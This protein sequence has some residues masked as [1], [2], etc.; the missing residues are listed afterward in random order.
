MLT[1]NPTLPFV[2]QRG[3]P[4]ATN[5]PLKQL[6]PFCHP[7]RS[8]GIC[9]FL[10]Q[11]PIPTGNPT[12][13][14]SSSN[15]SPPETTL[16]FVIPSEAEGSAV[17]FP[18][19]QFLLET[20]PHPCPPAT[21]LPLKQPSP[22]SSRAKP[23]DLQFPFPATNSYWKPHPTLVIPTGAKRSGGTC[24]SPTPIKFST[25]KQRR[26]KGTTYEE[27]QSPDSSGA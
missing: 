21:N 9:S 1:G 27:A 5:L 12:P 17:S 7:E 22:L 23:R 14:L 19:N 24:G 18:S 25:G 16:S 15:E 26:A 8:R 20:P 2:L 11:Q 3:C 4:P 10:S 6:S 13:P